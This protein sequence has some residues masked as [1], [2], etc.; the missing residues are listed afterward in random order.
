MKAL[1]HQ[2]ITLPCGNCKAYCNKLIEAY[3]HLLNQYRQQLLDIGEATAQ[4]PRCTL[5]VCQIDGSHP[6]QFFHAL[7]HWLCRSKLAD[8][9]QQVPGRLSQCPRPLRKQGTPVCSLVHE[10]CSICLMD[11]YAW[12]EVQDF[13]H[14]MGVVSWEW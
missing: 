7:G 4:Q 12:A 6:T 5:E 9:D 2:W 14:T 8:R 13:G 3:F 11:R 1:S 10:K